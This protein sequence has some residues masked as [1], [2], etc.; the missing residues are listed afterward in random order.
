MDKMTSL[1]IRDCEAE[2]SSLIAMKRAAIDCDMYNGGEVAAE[3]GEPEARAC[4]R[5]E[6]ITICLS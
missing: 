1:S 4:P 6:T 5:V 3:K 2:G